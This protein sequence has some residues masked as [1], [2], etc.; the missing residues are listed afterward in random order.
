MQASHDGSSDDQKGRIGFYTNDGNDGY[1]P[2]LAMTLDSAQRLTVIGDISAAGGFKQP[3]GF[4]RQNVAA[5]LSAVA[6]NIQGSSDNTEYVMPYA[7]SIIGISIAANAAR[8]A[9]TLT[10]DATIDGSVTGL[11]AILNASNT[12]YHYGTQAKDSDAFTA[13]QR[14]GVK[15]T[16]DASWAPTTADIVV[17]IFV[18]M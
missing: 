4:S 9:G 5:S 1:N 16:T 2:T 11:Q 17:T 6:L 13:G 12:Q 7:G 3:F 18:E 10:V 14:V 15:I 8:S